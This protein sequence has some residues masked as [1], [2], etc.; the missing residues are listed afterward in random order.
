MIES[1]NARKYILYAIGEIALVVIG[2]LIALQVNNWNTQ[3]HDKVKLNGY[4]Q[5]IKSNVNDDLEQLQ[6]LQTNLDSLRAQC[7]EAMSLLEKSTFTF[8][9]ALVLYLSLVNSFELEEFNCNKHGFESLKVSGLLDLLQGSELEYLLFD[10]YKMS[11]IITR[12][13]IRWNTYSQEMS[14]DIMKS[15]YTPQWV[16]NNVSAFNNPELL[17]D[18]VVGKQYQA[19]I[20][21]FF[22]NPAVYALYTKTV[23]DTEMGNMYAETINIGH[24]ILS[25]IDSRKHESLR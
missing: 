14:V 15:S 7:V 12:K 16:K 20:K 25:E 21:G 2:I 9:E 4:L 13:E 10:Y 23:G 17:T 18:P 11:D 22:S 6:T 19:V 3:S 24:E 1:G 8:D 5:S